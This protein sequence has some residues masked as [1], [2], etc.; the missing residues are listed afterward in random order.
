[1]KQIFSKEAKIGL[2]TIVSLVLLYFGINYL[3]GVNLFKPVN[4]YE[5]EFDNVNGVTISSPVYVEGFKVGLVR[6]IRYDYEKMDKIIVDVSLDEKMRI[7]KGSYI[8]IVNSFLG[9]AELHIHLNKYVDDYLKPGDRV[10]GRMGEEM[11]Q[12]VQEKILPSVEAMLPKIDSILVGLQALVNHPALRHSLEH[13]E[14][15]TSNLEI[16]TRRL[17]ALMERDVPGIVA[18]LKKITND[19][20]E[21]SGELKDLNLQQTFDHVNATLANLKVTTEK[22]NSTDNSLGLLLND[23]ALYDNLN[24]TAGNASKLLLD[25]REHPK[26]YVHFSVFGK[27]ES[28]K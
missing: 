19:F 2:V 10:E 16:S 9:G 1:M 14:R 22:F 13:V 24:S 7:N 6:E 15:P 17:N 11:M 3:K 26:R 5:V 23:R 18:D 25:L 8:T 28:S 12:S 20:S 21:V 4:H 27:K